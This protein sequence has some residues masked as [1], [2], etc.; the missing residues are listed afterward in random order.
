MPISLH[1]LLQLSQDA[2]ALLGG[3]Y[4]DTEQALSALAL[5][6]ATA[7][8]TPNASGFSLQTLL[9]AGNSCSAGLFAPRQHR[10]NLAGCFRTSRANTLQLV[11][12]KSKHLLVK[13]RGNG[14]AAFS[15]ALH[16][17]EQQGADKGRAP[18]AT[19]RQ[20]GDTDISPAQS[21]SSC[22]KPSLAGAGSAHPAVPPALSIFSFAV[23]N[24]CSHLQSP[25]KPSLLLPLCSLQAVM[26]CSPSA[27][28]V[29]LK[30]SPPASTPMP[31]REK[32]SHCPHGTTQRIHPTSRHR[33]SHPRLRVLL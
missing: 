22:F 7:P 27:S 4:H 21:P 6:E 33:C 25:C 17:S 11:K 15:F 14:D 16:G 12:Q 8:N 26:L 32:L 24:S 2:I 3:V 31:G 9:V 1:S 13:C 5:N 29:L 19:L 30:N 18:R 28:I 23:P 10:G 20:K